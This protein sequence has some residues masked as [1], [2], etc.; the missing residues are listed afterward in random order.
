MHANQPI[1]CQA[2]L[3]QRETFKRKQTAHSILGTA[4]A[5]LRGLLNLTWDC[6]MPF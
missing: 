2:I 3:M 1:L 4:T 5:H 6:S